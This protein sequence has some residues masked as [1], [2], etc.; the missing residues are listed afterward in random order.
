MFY[1]VRSRVGDPTWM[2]GELD[3]TQIHYPEDGS[4]KKGIVNENSKKLFE[5]EF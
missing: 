2:D 5:K 1:D 4:K 3:G